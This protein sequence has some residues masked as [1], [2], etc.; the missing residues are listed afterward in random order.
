MVLN[1]DKNRHIISNQNINS[2][3]YLAGRGM[4]A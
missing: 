4:A 2:G 3:S 1:S